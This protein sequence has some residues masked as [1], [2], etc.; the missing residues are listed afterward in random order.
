MEFRKIKALR[1]PNIWANSPVLEAWIDLKQWKDTSSKMIPGYVDR[2]MDWLPGL[3]ED[4]CSE[5]HRGGFLERLRDGTYPAHVLEHVALELQDLAGTP[6]GYG[7]ARSTREE[8]VYRIVVKYREEAVGRACLEAARELVLAA[9]ED[10]PYDVPALIIR[11]RELFLNVRRG[12][13]TE[14]MVEAAKARMIPHRQ[15]G[16]NSLVVLGHGARQRRIYTSLTDRIGSVANTVS[17]DKELVKF[18]LR[19]AGVPV[20]EGRPV[21]DEDDAWRAASEFHAP[22]V[23]KPRDGDYGLGV[24]VCLTTEDQVRAAYHRAR[25]VSEEILVEKYASGDVYRLLIIKSQL[26]AAVRRD[27][28]QVV[29]DGRSTVAQLIE[30]TN[31]DPRRGE[32]VTK[33]LP[34]IVVDEDARHALAS[35]SFS[36]ESVPAEG[37]RVLVHLKPHRLTGA[38]DTDVTDDI[39]PDIIRCAALATRVIGLEVAGIDLIAPDIGRPLTEQGG[40]ILE[41]NAGPAIRPHME[42]TEGQPRPVAA[43]ILETIMP[44]GEDGRIPLVAV[45]GVNGKTTTTRLIA[46]L[47]RGAGLCVGMTCTDG[48]YIGSRRIYAG[49]CAG[50]RSAHDVLLNPDVEAAVLEAARGGI[51]REGLGFDRCSVAVVTNIGEGDHLGLE[52]IHSAE[53]LVRVKRTIVDVVLPTGWAVL[54][55]ADPLVAGMADACRGGVIYFARDGEHPVIREFLAA[56]KRAAFVR[57]GSI[58]LAEGQHRERL[59]TLEHVPITR[60]GRIGFQVENALAAAAAVW[61]LGHPLGLIREGLQSFESKP[62]VTPGRFNVLDAR[63]ATVIVDFGH[64]PSALEALV[65]SMRAFHGRRRTVVLSADGDRRDEVIVRQAEILAPHFDLVVLYEEQSRN[66]GRASGEIST[67]LRQGLATA[68]RGPEIVEVVGEQ[69]AISHALNG[70]EDGDILLVLVD[71]VDSS[72]ALVERLVAERNQT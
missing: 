69:T 52:D 48:I 50:P 15:V 45:T 38:T 44:P 28:A 37:A 12:P 59:T 36:L 60:G 8:G 21:A 43:A 54:N 71:A 26:T 34:K 23:V 51:L 39:H 61:A 47:L 5:G 53:D 27:P 68:L 67:L 24:M 2:L 20:P 9:M 62:E 70:L 66:R 33:P 58:V 31:A 7:R 41:V 55:A 25:K 18:L 72:L 49:D 65:E 4:E 63:G 22:V 29:G 19:G 3:I 56:G 13:N 35:Q 1:G 16:P 14:F 32:D 42:P 64:N 30:Q 10:R 40:V 11:L 6:V 57:D 17:S 46:H